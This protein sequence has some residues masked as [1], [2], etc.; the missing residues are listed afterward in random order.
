MGLSRSPPN[1]LPSASFPICP[2][3]RIRR[4][5]GLSDTQVK[6][7][8]G[9]EF[10]EPVGRHLG[11]VPH[12]GLAGAQR[13]RRRR[14]S[15]ILFGLAAELPADHAEQHGKAESSAERHPA[16]IDRRLLPPFRQRRPTS[17]IATLITNGQVRSL[18]TDTTEGCGMR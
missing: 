6:R 7:K 8:F 2:A 12:P 3:C 10:P 11:E 1:C 15:R 5:I 4:I 13:C 9:V 14:E 18:C 17:S 16:A